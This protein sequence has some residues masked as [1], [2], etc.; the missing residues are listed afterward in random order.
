MASDIVPAG[1]EEKKAGP[2]QTSKSIAAPKPQ[3]AEPQAAL[4]H[5]NGEKRLAQSGPAVHQQHSPGSLAP[6]GD[7]SDGILQ[8]QDKGPSESDDVIDD[9]GWLEGGRFRVR[10]ILRKGA[11]CGSRRRMLRNLHGAVSA[12][13]KDP[14]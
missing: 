13:G 1:P 8:G 11:N 12:Q 6:E 5:V 14:G 10:R 7:G 2:L 9:T 4:H 3:E